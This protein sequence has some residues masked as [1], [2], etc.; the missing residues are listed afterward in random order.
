MI[1]SPLK[2]EKK[3]PANYSVSFTTG[4]QNIDKKT[5]N[6]ECKYTLPVLIIHSNC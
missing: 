2:V 5:Y 3:N 6:H 4:A 1:P